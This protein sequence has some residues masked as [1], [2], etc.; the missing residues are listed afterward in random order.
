[1][2]DDINNIMIWNFLGEKTLL[3]SMS[4]FPSLCF[5]VL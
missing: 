1:M 3:G 5:T 4:A 2:Y